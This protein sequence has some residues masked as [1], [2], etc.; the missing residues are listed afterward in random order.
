MYIEIIIVALII[1]VMAE[2]TGLASSKRLVTD[3][4]DLVYKNYKYEK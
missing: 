2:Y 1:F 3:N 4:K